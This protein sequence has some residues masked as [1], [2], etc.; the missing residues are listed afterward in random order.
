[1]LLMPLFIN[2]FVVVDGRTAPEDTSLQLHVIDAVVDKLVVVVDGR[3]APGDV[4]GRL[5]V[6][7]LLC[8]RQQVKNTGFKCPI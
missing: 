5:H 4:H 2:F 3:T 7:Q 1:M 8:S 6:W